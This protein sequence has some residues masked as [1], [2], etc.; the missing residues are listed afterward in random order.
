MEG[1]EAT[2]IELDADGYPDCLV[3]SE[4]DIEL[5]IVDGDSLQGQA[6]LR[7][8]SFDEDTCPVAPETCDIV[9]DIVAER[10]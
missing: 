7:T 4:I 8:E 5:L 3:G 1:A 6:I 2:D 9:M 10:Q